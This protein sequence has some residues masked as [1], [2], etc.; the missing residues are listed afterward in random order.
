MVWNALPVPL[1]VEYWRVRNGTSCATSILASWLLRVTTDGVPRILVRESPCS[2]R[3]IS[4]KLTPD[5]FSR[6]MPTVVPLRVASD[7]LLVLPVVVVV[8][9]VAALVLAPRAAVHR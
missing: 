2:A 8:P 5:A 4:A 7:R 3:S 9:V 6:P 1:V